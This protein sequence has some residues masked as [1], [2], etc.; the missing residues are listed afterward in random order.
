MIIK[1]DE[2]VTITK[3]DSLECR[4]YYGINGAEITRVMLITPKGKKI[5]KFHVETE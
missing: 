3:D 5:L 4:I 1:F 2:E